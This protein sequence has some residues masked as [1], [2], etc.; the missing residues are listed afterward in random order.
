MEVFKRQC[1]NSQISPQR[2]LAKKIDFHLLNIFDK[3]LWNDWRNR[4]SIFVMWM[5]FLYESCQS[6]LAIGHIFYIIVHAIPCYA[7]C[8]FN[9]G[10]FLLPQNFFTQSCNFSAKVESLLNISFNL[11]GKGLFW[12]HFIDDSILICFLSWN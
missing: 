1:K 5:P 6:F 11:T 10:I 9:L 2:T 8:L 3:K 4:S 12:N 7:V